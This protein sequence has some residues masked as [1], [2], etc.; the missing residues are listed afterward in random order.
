M[1][2]QET[3]AAPQKQPSSHWTSQFR[4]WTDRTILALCGGLI[5]FS[6]LQLIQY[7]YGRDQGIYAVV[8]ESIVHGGMPYRDA[9]DFKPPGI[10]FVYALARGLFGSQEWAIRA[11]ES[12]SM[13]ALIPTFIVLGRRL[14]RS[15]IAGFFGA[16]VAIVVHCQLEFWHTAQPETFG[17]VLT[18]LALL[19]V[20]GPVNAAAGQRNPRRLVAGWLG[21][22]LLFGMAG[23]MKPHLAGG[24][25]VAGGY[26]AYRIRQ[27][28]RP[29][30]DCLVPL[31][32]LGGGVVLAIG[33]CL[34]LF[35][36]RGAWTGLHH[37]LFVF[38]PGYAST[39]WDWGWWPNFLYCA[40]ENF[41]VEASAP[42]CAGMAMAVA[43]HGDARDRPGV[44]LLGGII[45]VHLAGIAIQS[46]FFPYHFDA[47]YPLGALL[48]GFGLHKAWEL[49]HKRRELG[50]AAFFF[51]LYALGRARTSMRD[52]DGTWWVR[53]SKRLHAMVSGSAQERE[54]LIQELSSVADVDYPSNRSVA[55]WIDQH[56]ASNDTV[57]IWGF[58]PFIYHAAARKPGSKYIYNVPQRVA[59]AKGSDLKEQARRD[60]MADL[61]SSQPAVIVVEH[62]DVFPVV[63]GD[64]LDSAAS[65]ADF[66][67]LQELLDTKYAKQTTIQDF[68][69]FLRRTNAP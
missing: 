14:F 45:A 69:L 10:F 23:L 61:G 28:G 29:W 4:T 39:T 15:S 31:G 36:A 5:L 24:A 33:G 49:A 30:R 67:A 53:S 57:Y 1:K 12:L 44:S 32:A 56:T 9:W 41:A 47:T 7:R 18:M 20:T 37:A 54:G 25:A 26:L 59:F 65:L 42:L 19:L 13:L 63:T 34:G 48:A 8:G 64:S 2:I 22:G 46:K 68:D 51:C 35:A 17:G 60:L 52:L 43:L 50:V 58:E 3:F 6:L 38:A 27:H 16:T 40:F 66:G 21:A 62:R 55:E 11:I